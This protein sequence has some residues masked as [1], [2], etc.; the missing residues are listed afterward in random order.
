MLLLVLIVAG[1]VQTASAADSIRVVIL[2]FEV[3]AP[4]PQ[5][6]FS[7]QIADVL[8]QQLQQEGIAVVEFQGEWKSSGTASADLDRIRAVGVEAGA[9][10]VIWG[11]LTSFGEQYS[12]DARVVKT[13]EEGA[14]PKAFFVEGRNL[15]TLVARLKGISSSIG[16]E[17]L[18]RK[19]ISTIEVEGNVRIEADAI[20]RVIKTRAGDV[21]KAQPLTRDLK[22]IYQMGYFNDVRVGARDFSGGKAIVFTVQE[23][24]TIRNIA[25]KSN[26]KI[27]DKELKENLTL[28]TG[29]ILNIFKIQ[30]N[31]TIIEDLYKEKNYHHIQVTYKT[32]ELKNN[33]ADLEFKIVEGK[34]SRIENIIFDGNSEYPDK[35]LK[36]LVETS[37]AWIFSFITEAGDLDHEK[38]NQDVAILTSF[39]HNNG[40]IDARV[41]EPDVVFTEDGI[42]VTFKIHEGKRYKVGKVNLVGEFVL[43]EKKLKENLKLSDEEFFSQSV[44][45][46]DVLVIRDIYSDEGYAYAQIEPEMQRRDQELLVDV[47]YGIKKGT[48]VYYEKIIIS[49]NTKTRD[50]VIRRELK[51]YERELYSGKRMKRGIRNL[52][53]LDFFE[54]IQ[55]DTPKGSADDQMVLKI[56]VKEKSTGAFSLGG[57]Y[58][59]VEQVYFK[60]SVS[61]KNLFGRAQVLKLEA[62]LGG[63]TQKFNLSFTEP[64]LFDIPL[65]GTANVYSL[66]TDYDSY[67]KQSIGAGIGVGYPVYDYTRAYVNYRFDSS[68][69][70]NVRDFAADSVKDLTGTNVTSSVTSSLVYDSRD[71]RA[72]TKKGSRHLLS[73]EYA[74]LGGTIG[75]MKCI[76]ETGWYFPLFWKF[77]GFLHGKGG[78]VS[79]NSG[80]LLPDYAKFFIG[81]MNSMRGFDWQD[82][83]P[84]EINSS[85][86]QAYIGG[87]KYVHFNTELRFP[88][89]EEAG[90]IGLVFFDTGD[91]YAGYEA[92]ALDALRESAGFGFRWYSP[93]GPI[94]LENAYILDPKLGESEGGKWEFSIGTAF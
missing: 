87:E 14:P 13:F 55:I 31:I 6:D 9:D 71:R 7:A 26:K 82:L 72:N 46:Q 51:V 64:W 76:A 79:Q 41:G 33:Q 4:T 23:K 68:K 50:K 2:P 94:R 36:K 90:V 81:G 89:V 38:L 67:D 78:Y 91:V 69:V 53:F 77:T 40:Y 52:Y 86:I 10:R 44:M 34:R 75:Y 17:V 85:G 5:R 88:L 63:L 19:T 21:F 27:K 70:S 42:D 39:Y 48:L 35:R 3:Y 62:S 1:G 59:S 58:S 54:D 12:L 74:G 37:E 15:G 30:N 49:G 45:R 80:M 83:A 24:P 47:T 56:N 32:I 29:S 25:F 20:K 43:P 57:G 11:S 66:D 16:M 8:K 84:T 28:R 65:S 93:M 73:V 60:G 18:N 61:Q 22:K 92:V